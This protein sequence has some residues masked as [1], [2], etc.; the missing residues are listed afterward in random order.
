MVLVLPAPKDMTALGQVQG[1]A[2]RVL[3]GMGWLPHDSQLRR[4]GLLLWKR[5]RRD[6]GKYLGKYYV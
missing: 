2:K 6:D 1:R 3:R 5:G 4:L